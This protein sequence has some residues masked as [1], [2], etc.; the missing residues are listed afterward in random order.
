MAILAALCAH[1]GSVAS[2]WTTC[3]HP[4]E[5]PYT[6]SNA[7]EIEY[8][9]YENG[10]CEHFQ[11]FLINR[12]TLEIPVY[13]LRDTSAAFAAYATYTGPAPLNH[14]QLMAWEHKRCFSIYIGAGY[15][16]TPERHDYVLQDH[17]PRQE[18][19][20]VVPA[21]NECEIYFAIYPLT[22]ESTGELAEY[23]DMDCKSHFFL[24]KFR[25]FSE[26]DESLCLGEGRETFCSKKNGSDEKD[27]ED[28]RNDENDGDDADSTSGTS[29]TAN[30][31]L[32]TISYTAAL[33]FAG[34]LLTSNFI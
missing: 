31:S 18:G 1:F 4:P 3:I 7:T 10:R 27:G 11:N 26:E 5:R 25:V 14:Q 19:N 30:V 20:Q 15:I 13:V 34:A 9:C 8:Y 2:I 32:A 6:F 16:P 17:G 33:L 12:N 24:E 21:V 22:A 29:S 28:Y 23:A